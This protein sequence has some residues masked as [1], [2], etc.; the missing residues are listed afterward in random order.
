[1]AD[2]RAEI[3]SLNIGHPRPHEFNGRSVVSSMVKTPVPGP[4]QVDF[5]EIHDNSFAQPQYHGTPDSIVY[6]YGLKS[7]QSFVERLGRD[8]YDIGSTGE[9][10]TVDDLDET[11]VHVG[12]VFQAGETQLVATFPRIPCGKVSICLKH[13]DGQRAMQECLRSGVYFRVLK[14]GR[15]AR[16]DRLERVRASNVHLP[17][18]EVY[19]VVVQNLTPQADQLARAEA[20]GYFPARMLTKWKTLATARQPSEPLTPQD[21]LNSIALKSA[22]SNSAPRQ[23]PH[24]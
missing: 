7:A 23:V 14:P 13:E 24:D 18:A 11:Q 20:S 12:D 22:A 3:L 6:A 17:I 15:I 4:L 19:Q 1:M 21:A 5:T 9:T 8:R 16:G 10:L 2:L